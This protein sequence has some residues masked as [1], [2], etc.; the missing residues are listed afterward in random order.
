LTVAYDAIVDGVIRKAS[1]YIG[2][3]VNLQSNKKLDIEDFLYKMDRGIIDTQIVVTPLKGVTTTQ[4]DTPEAI[5]TLEMRLYVT[6]QLDVFHAIENVEKYYSTKCNI[7]EE[8]A[9]TEQHA[10]YNVLPPTFR[11]T[12]EKNCAP[13]ERRKVTQ[14]QR[15]MTAERPGPEPWAIFR[16]HYRSKGWY[17]S[18][19]KFQ[20]IH[21]TKPHRCDHRAGDEYDI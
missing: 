17:K 5:G 4:N 15:R 8:D 1:S 6:R 21:L 12:F 3:T 9:E 14:W 10:N 11:T 7:E 13:L 2:M 20:R 16:F 19:S 18:K